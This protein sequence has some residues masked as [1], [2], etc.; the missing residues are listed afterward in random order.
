[1]TNSQRCCNVI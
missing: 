1:M